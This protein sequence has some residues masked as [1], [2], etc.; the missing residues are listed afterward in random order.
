M[1]ANTKVTRSNPLRML[2]AA[3][4]LSTGIPGLGHAANTSINV[5]LTE[6]KFFDTGIGPL[7]AAQGFGDISKGAHSTFIKLPPGFVTPL[8]SHTEDYY[9]VVI[10]GVVA[11]AVD[12]SVAD[13]PLAP[14]SYWFQ[15]GK[16]AH[17]TKCLSANEC[18]LFITQPGKFDFVKST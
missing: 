12:A 13:V 6:M 5:P 18:V 3:L 17:V 15:K 9:G 10:A 7:K 14:G 11:N 2:I 4:A 8:H 1:K 16:A